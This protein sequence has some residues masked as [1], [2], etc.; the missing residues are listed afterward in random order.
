[1]PP[2]A[3]F[4]I[5]CKWTTFDIGVTMWMQ[6]EFGYTIGQVNQVNGSMLAS[7]FFQPNE[8]NRLSCLWFQEEIRTS[9]FSC[10]IIYAVRMK[11]VRR[12]WPLVVLRLL[13]RLVR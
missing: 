11:C 12:P 3:S 1:M 10:I 13:T 9:T 5:S 7:H 6:E 8:F 4:I 2:L